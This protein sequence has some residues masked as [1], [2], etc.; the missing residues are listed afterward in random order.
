MLSGTGFLVDPAEPLPLRSVPLCV[1]G[2]AIVP[3]CVSVMLMACHG[4]ARR[5]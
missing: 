3:E 1:N 4:G 2:V 5:G